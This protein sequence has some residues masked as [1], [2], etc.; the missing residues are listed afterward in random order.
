MKTAFL[1]YKPVLDYEDSEHSY[2]VC[3]TREKAQEIID[4]C[5]S[6][7]DRMK[8]KIGEQPYSHDYDDQ[9]EWEKCYDE[10]CDRD[11]INSSSLKDEI[12]DFF[13]YRD[14][15]RYEKQCLKIK[16]IPYYI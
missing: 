8:E 2:C 1:I 14:Y 13:L 15:E 16:E 12:F 4:K 5:F 7:F 9:K 6:N 11:R 10:W 3:S